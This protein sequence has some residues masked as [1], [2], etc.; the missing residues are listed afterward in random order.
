MAEFK[1][2]LEE[3]R[4]RAAESKEHYLREHAN[5]TQVRS[6]LQ[7][8]R[9]DVCNEAQKYDDMN[10]EM[11]R[12]IRDQDAELAAAAQIRREAEHEKTQVTKQAQEVASVL[13]QM[14]V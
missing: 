3:A 14:E 5:L 8:E 1:K 9:A 13:A 4:Q 11:A 7:A 6:R 12:K 2:E 10:G